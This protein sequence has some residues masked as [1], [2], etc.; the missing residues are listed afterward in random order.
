LTFLSPVSRHAAA[1]ACPV[2]LLFDYVETQRDFTKVEQ[3]IN[4][5]NDTY[6]LKLCYVASCRTSYYRALPASS[7]RQRIDLSPFV[8]DAELEWLE[9]YRRETVRHILEHGGIQVTEEHLAVCQDVP[10][11]AVFILYLQAMGADD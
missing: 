9:G 10:T 11:F 7:R 4:D 5:L 1:G 8:Q 6:L 3:A 2:L